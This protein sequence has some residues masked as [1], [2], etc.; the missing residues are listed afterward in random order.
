[1]FPLLLLNELRFALW[2]IFVIYHRNQMDPL[3]PAFAKL[4]RAEAHIEDLQAAINSFL[5]SNPYRLISQVNEDGAKEVWSIK[6]DPIPWEIDAIAADAVHNLRTPLDK[7]LAVGFRHPTIHTK[8]AIAQKL[9]F[10]GIRHFNELKTILASLEEHLSRPV[11]N[12]LRDAEPY[13]GGAGQIFSAI[14]TLD[15]RDKHRSL[16]E[17]I[18]LGFATAE[19]RSMN[20]RKGSLLRVGSP[21]GHHLDLAFDEAGKPC[22]IAPRD[23]TGP[24]MRLRVP[25]TSDYFLEFLS[26]YDDLEVLT[27]VGAQYNANVQPILNVAFRELRSFEGKP[28]LDV[29]ETMRQAVSSTLMKFR[30][31]FF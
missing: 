16:L 2:S 28:V 27:T 9:K 4:R 20:F 8:Q 14:N 29:L 3:E 17:P 5:K 24:T 25:S 26:P 31:D 13:E 10:P 12:F 11:I 21:R 18:K 19:I 15:N 22:W 7:M 23:D 30:S 1:V 6:I